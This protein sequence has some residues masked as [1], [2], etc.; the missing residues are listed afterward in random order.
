MVTRRFI[1]A[2]IKRETQKYENFMAGLSQNH[3]TER[4]NLAKATAKG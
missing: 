4:L 3:V 1:E 2:H